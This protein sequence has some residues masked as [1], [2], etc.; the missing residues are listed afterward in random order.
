V[1]C[2]SAFFAG[3]AGAVI[4]PVTGS[5]SP[6][7]YDFSISL[8]LVAVL[9]IAGRQPVVGAFVAAVLYIVIPGYISQ[10]LLKWTPVIFGG[11]AVLTAMFGGLPFIDR[12]RSSKRALVRNGRLSPAR[13]RLSPPTAGPAS[14]SAPSFSEAAPMLEAP[15]PVGVSR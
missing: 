12:L 1:F 4:A 9:F 10:G 15:E 7:P 5:V 8:L 14:A 2:T 13:S 11:G 3:I 6:S